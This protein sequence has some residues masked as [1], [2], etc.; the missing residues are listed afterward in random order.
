[1][2]DT[3]IILKIYKVFIGQ[4]LIICPVWTIVNQVKYTVI[5]LPVHLVCFYVDQEKT[6]QTVHITNVNSTSFG[7]I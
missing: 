4:K 6:A 1:M 3:I 7:R 5:S 2:E